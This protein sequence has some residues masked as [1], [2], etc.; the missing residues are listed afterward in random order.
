MSLNEVGSPK[1]KG[2]SKK[3]QVMRKS[4][5]L[6]GSLTGVDHVTMEHI[7]MDT[8]RQVRSQLRTSEEA[9]EEDEGG[10]SKEQVFRY[11]M[12]VWHCAGK[13]IQQ[14]SKFQ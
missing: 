14:D 9:G 13:H 12:Q 3:Q 10:P 8:W 5:T 1:S 6:N 11:I 2:K 7:C 4:S